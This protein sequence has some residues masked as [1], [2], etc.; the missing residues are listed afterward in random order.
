MAERERAVHAEDTVERVSCD[1]LAC[2]L[3]RRRA[4]PDFLHVA[5]G[6]GLGTRTLCFLGFPAKVG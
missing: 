4:S 2:Q 1:V 3:E 6:I 5:Q